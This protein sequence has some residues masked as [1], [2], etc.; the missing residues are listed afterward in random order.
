M[1]M[2]QNLE[3]CGAH[4]VVH[5][6]ERKRLTRKQEEEPSHRKQWITPNAPN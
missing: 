3:A 6:K 1:L 4:L 2:G 5:K